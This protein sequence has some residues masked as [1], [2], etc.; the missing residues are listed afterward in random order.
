MPAVDFKA[1]AKCRHHIPKQKRRLSIHQQM[2]GFSTGAEPRSGRHQRLSPSA[3][4]DM[5]RHRENKAEEAR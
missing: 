3:Q 4:G 1:N 2:Y 5:V